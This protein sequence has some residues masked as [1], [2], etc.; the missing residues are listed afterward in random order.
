MQRLSLVTWHPFHVLQELQQKLDEARKE[1]ETKFRAL[2]DSVGVMPD[3]DFAQFVQ[4]VQRDA[5]Y[6]VVPSDEKR[7]VRPSPGP[8]V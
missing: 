5:R 1:W 8:V 3:T 4:E 7:K 6:I 2:M